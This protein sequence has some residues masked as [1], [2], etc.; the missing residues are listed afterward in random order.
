MSRD[1]GYSVLIKFSNILLYKRKQGVVLSDE[2][3]AQLALAMVVLEAAG[4]MEKV[5]V[6]D[7]REFYRWRTAI[8]VSLWQEAQS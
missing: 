4:L 7:G 5:S 2:E 8:P 3:E 6:H 1:K